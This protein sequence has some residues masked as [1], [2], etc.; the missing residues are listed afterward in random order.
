MQAGKL[1][2]RITITAPDDAGSDWGGEYTY[3]TF[4]T[5]WASIEPLSGREIMDLRQ[6]NA[7][8]SHRII[9]RY[10]KGVKPSMRISFQGKT[11]YITAVMDAQS[12]HEYL[13]I[14]AREEVD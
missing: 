2:N 6:D 9:C 13:E 4:A 12:R 7:E 10:V 11:Y 1:R 3:S 14:L 8:V 5:V